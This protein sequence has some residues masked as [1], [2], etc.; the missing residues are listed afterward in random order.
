VSPHQTKEFVHAGVAQ[1]AASSDQAQ[2]DASDLAQRAERG[3]QAPFRSLGIIGLGLI[4]GSLALAA[5]RAWPAIRIVGVDHGAALEAAR[6]LVAFDALADAPD[7]VRGAELVVLAAPVRQNALV[8]RELA[9]GLA[10]DVLVTDVGSTKRAMAEAAGELPPQLSFIGGHPLAGAARGGLVL[11]RGDLFEGRR[12]LLTPGPTQP[13]HDHLARLQA[14][15]SGLGA[16]PQVMG[17][18]EHDRLLAYLSHL[19]QLTAS[20]LI[21]TVGRAVGDRIDLAGPGLAD[22]T[23]LAS[24]PSPI[25]EDICVT[26]ADAIGPALDALIETLQSVRDRLEDPPAVAKLFGSAQAWRE[27]LG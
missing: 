11:A 12:W 13:L 18:E 16:V 9:A 1:P 10:Q 4:G 14:F 17:A 19:P 3:V 20:A 15:V 22:T 25:W 2:G 8:L 21:D 24:S 5:R 27:R 26:N 7:A 23:R 6:W